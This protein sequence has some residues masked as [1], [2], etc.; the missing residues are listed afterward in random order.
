MNGSLFLLWCEWSGGVV[1]I[2]VL[3]DVKPNVVP[4]MV[5]LELLGSRS[6][7]RQGG[8]NHGWFV[9]GGWGEFVGGFVV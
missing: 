1:W 7:R 2:I 8:S 4:V 6:G 5:H 3:V 9:C